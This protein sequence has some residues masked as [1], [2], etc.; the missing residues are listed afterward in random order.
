MT[1][2]ILPTGCKAI[3]CSVEYSYFPVHS[4]TFLS[5]SEMFLRLREDFLR[6]QDN[7]LQGGDCNLPRLDNN[8]RLP[9]TFLDHLRCLL[10]LSENGL[11]H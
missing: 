6:L 2:S 5:R 4:E 1:S 7:L 3:L 8:R 10:H 11:R 9:E